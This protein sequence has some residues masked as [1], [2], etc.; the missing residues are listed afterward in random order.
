M[1]AYAP[2]A[3][4]GWW[5][6]VELPAQE[7][8]AP[9]YA[10]V[11]RTGMLLAA[12][13]VFATL[14]G[15]L[16]A[17]KMVVPIRALGLP[18]ALRVSAQGDLGQRIK[19]NTGDELEALANQFNDMA[20]KLQESYADLEKKVE[21]RTYELSESLAQQTATA[22]VLKVISRSTFDLQTVLDTLVES[23]ATLCDAEMSAITQQ[24]GD[25]YY[26]IATHNFPADAAVSGRTL[27]HERNTETVVGRTLLSGTATQIPDV[28]ADPLYGE[29]GL[30]FQK[31]AGFRTLLGVPL[32][33][34]GI[35]I[36]VIALLRTS[37]RPFTDKQIELV[38]TFAD[39][40]V[41]AIENVRL[42]D[43]VEARTRELTESLEQQTATSEVLQVISSSPGELEPVFQAMLENATRICEAKFGE[44][45]LH[46]DGAFSTVA[47]HDVPAK[48]RDERQRMPPFGRFRTFLWAVWQSRSA[49]FI[50]T[51]S[52]ASRAT[53]NAFLHLWRSPRPVARGPC[54]WCRC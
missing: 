17:R 46:D 14:A 45:F 4:L 39:Q 21:T 15:L 8:Y 27:S 52:R 18:P 49:S 33:R 34:E 44:M 10:S 20:G 6:F 31:I 23:A 25:A 32:L 16:L 54:C 51:T 28:L 9:L 38:Q 1:T 26:Y 2:V 36:G 13:L 24:K 40:A 41:I 35:P 11:T 50:S 22:D 5:M 3:P 53:L 42:F 37:V 7:A 47:L 30:R 12:G 43:E 19:V 48:L 29:M